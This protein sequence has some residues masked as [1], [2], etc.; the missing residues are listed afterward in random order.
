MK[1]TPLFL[2]CFFSCKTEISPSGVHTLAPDGFHLMIKTGLPEIEATN[3]LNFS[4]KK[5]HVQFYNIGCVTERSRI[6][7]INKVNDSISLIVKSQFGN[8]WLQNLRSE[9]DT[10]SEVREIAFTELL[11]YQTD[12]DAPFYYLVSPGLRKNEY[13]VRVYSMDYNNSKIHVQY[14]LGVNYKKKLVFEISK[15]VDEK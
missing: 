3:Q 10:L 12:H 9:L 2:F 4:A 7:S 8:N 5:Y 11:K 14:Y 13:F 6:D 1:Y 15:P